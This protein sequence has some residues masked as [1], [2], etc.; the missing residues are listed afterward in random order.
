VAGARALYADTWVSMGDEETA[1][2]RR[3]D[4]GPYRLDDALLD[5]AAPGA[6]A[7]HCL[8]AHAGDEITAEV[9][10]GSR[11]AVWDQAENRMHA[12]AAL[13]AHVLAPA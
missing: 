11:S 13:L 2:A 4:L 10:Y 6:V 3:R 5:A 12:Q 9:L 7:L 1:E 8:P